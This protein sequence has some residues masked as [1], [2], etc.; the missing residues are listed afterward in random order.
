MSSAIKVI[1]L[2]E[3][4]TDPNGIYINT[5]S[6]S[7]SDWQRDLSPF[8][9]GPCE[10][11]DGYIA[12]RMEN[13][14]QYSKVYK[15][16]TDENGN[17]TPAYYDW[18]ELGWKNPRPVRY[19]L[20]KGLKPLYS[21][22]GN[23]FIKKYPYVEARKKIYIP[24]YS[25]AVTKTKGFEHLTEIYE[26]ICVNNSIEND[27]SN[28]ITLYLRDFDAYRHEEM[29]LTLTD[30][31]NNPNKKCGHAFVLMMLLTNDPILKE[32]QLPPS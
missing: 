16:Y 4:Q 12:L 23:P 18:A 10:L 5:T 25:K 22:W 19:P 17:P 8:H 1:S 2:F 27:T 32:C 26:E 9:L 14:W 20:G 3:K 24:L 7:E 31:V 6:K 13:A 29:G 15:E 28:Q 30:V 21:V 11:Y